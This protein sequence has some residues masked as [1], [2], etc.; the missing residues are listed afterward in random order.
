MFIHKSRAD[1][2]NKIIQCHS[3]LESQDYAELKADDDENDDDN[4]YDAK[5]RLDI[6]H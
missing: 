2:T 5:G 1:D 4:A 6:G 3:V